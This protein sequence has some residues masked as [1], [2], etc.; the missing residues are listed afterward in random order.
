MPLPTHLLPTT[1]VGSYPQPNWLVNRQKSGKA[2]PG[3]VWLFTERNP[4]IR[5]RQPHPAWSAS[6]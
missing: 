1:V 5:M 2:R 4:K 6:R 3:V